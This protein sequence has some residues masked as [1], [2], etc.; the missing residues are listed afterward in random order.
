MQN[1]PT[2]SELTRA[3][4]R[5]D[6]LEY[7]EGK[8]AEMLEAALAQDDICTL[9]LLAV[10]QA[11]SLNPGQLLSRRDPTVREPR[12][13][14]A[15]IG[16]EPSNTAEMARAFDRSQKWNHRGI[17][18]MLQLHDITPINDDPLDGRN[19]DVKM[20][21]AWRHCRESFDEKGM[22]NT[23]VIMVIFVVSAA[24]MEIGHPMGI[25]DHL[26]NYLVLRGKAEGTEYVSHDFLK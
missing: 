3:R 10:T 1:G 26:L 9:L 22:P 17:E 4:H 16:V 25:P 20:K 2:Y 19:V 21:N 11:C 24:Q 18:G 8:V 5:V 14:R 13:L 23:P 6:C 12:Y 7:T 15:D